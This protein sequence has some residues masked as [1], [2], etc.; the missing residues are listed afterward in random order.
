[1]DFIRVRWLQK[2][3][4]DL[5]SAYDHIAAS[6][7]P[8]AR[9]LYLKLTNAV[10]RLAEFP[11]SG[12]PGVLPATRELVVTATPYIVVYRVNA[13]SVEVLRVFHSARNPD[14]I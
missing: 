3:V 12:R 13:G 8:A 6:N 9:H 5:D 11:H 2:A 10:D 7:Q 1:M 14:G 4:R